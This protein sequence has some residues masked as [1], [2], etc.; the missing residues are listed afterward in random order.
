MER[1]KDIF[2][3]VF[4]DDFG[5]RPL[6]IYLGGILALVSIIAISGLIAALMGRAACNNT[7]D[8]MGVAYEWRMF[9]GCF[10]EFDGQM[11]PLDVWKHLTFGAMP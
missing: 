5:V 9:G 8:V 7:S 11:V 4:H 10:L 6:V 3:D 1:L 2:Y